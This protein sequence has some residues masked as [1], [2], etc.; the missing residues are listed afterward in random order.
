MKIV[1]VDYSSPSSLKS[2]LS[3]IEVVVST[4][5][6]AGGVS[7]FDIAAAAKD[8]GVKLFVPSEVGLVTDLITDSAYA[9]KNEVKAKLKEIDLPFTIYYT[10]LFPDMILAPCVYF[11]YI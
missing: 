7:Q 3:N 2:A 4:L 5:G 11:F 8:V 10:G 1:V 9:S 6:G